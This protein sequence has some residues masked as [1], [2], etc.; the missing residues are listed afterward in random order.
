MITLASIII[1]W[2]HVG[3]DQLEWTAIIVL[4][5]GLRDPLL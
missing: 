2:C 1:N 3:T 4:E 5:Q